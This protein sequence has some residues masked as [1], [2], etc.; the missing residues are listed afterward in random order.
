MDIDLGL[1]RKVVK[2]SEF[3]SLIEKS[4]CQ[5]SFLGQGDTF[6]SIQLIAELAKK[7]RKQTQ[8]WAKRLKKPTTQQT[9]NGD[10]KFL[11]DHFQYKAD[12]EK[13]NLKSPKCA[14]SKRFDGIDCK[15][16][17]LIASTLLL[18]Q[19]INHYIRKI[20]Q[21]G[22][23]EDQYTHVYV[24]VPK[25]QKTNKL[26]KGYYVVDA[27]THDN[28]EPLFIEKYDVFMEAMPHYGLNGLAMS[29]ISQSIKAMEKLADI[30]N[31]AGVL[32]SI[33]DAMLIRVNRFVNKGIDP[34]IAISRNGI[35]I[36]GQL[37]R[38]QQPG[39][40]IEI[41]EIFV[42]TKS[43]GLQRA[44][45]SSLSKNAE[46]TS[47][48]GNSGGGSIDFGNV[49]NT[50]NDD[51]FQTA[52]SDIGDFFGG[53]F[54]GG[55]Y[56]ENHVK[57]N[58]ERLHNEHNKLVDEINN[59][60]SNQ[61]FNIFSQKIARLRHISELVEKAFIK[62][63]SEGWSN[64]SESNLQA[65]IDIAKRY[66][67]QIN[68]AIDA[69]V[70]QFFNISGSGGSVSF[71][72]EGWEK[73]KGF[74]GMFLGSPVVFTKQYQNLQPKQTNIPAFKITK[75]LTEAIF[76]KKQVDTGSFL[77][78]LKNIVLQF[79]GNDNNNNSNNQTTPNNSH[80]STGTVNTNSPSKAGFTQ[81]LL[82]G[83]LIAGGLFIGM[84]KM[85]KKNGKLQNIK[86]N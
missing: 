71:S 58:A 45:N 75:K 19:N 14:W 72:S 4:S 77:S 38:F 26:N 15:T 23:I 53:I 28:K 80:Q 56:K 62:K 68:K 59:S 46:F 21:P 7:H 76:Q 54:G 10:Y 73:E 74:F 39:Q 12:A 40:K 65:S 11:Y 32:K 2:N 1:R 17:S 25:D 48:N 36:E 33:T 51:W 64:Q 8:K 9:V 43:Q 69:Y 86:S 16:Y 55:F 57:E 66:N 37:F 61:N 47:T 42:Q 13:Q 60:L 82:L 63:K 79:L 34:V 49:F 20:K 29:N 50:S 5:S 31:D 22:F 18:N 83:S 24:I 41:P 78:D 3:D 70:S 84:R 81:N 27:T 30:L 67:T 52:L 85:G 44:V 6:L 35:V